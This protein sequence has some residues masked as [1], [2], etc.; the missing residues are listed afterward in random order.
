MPLSDLSRPAAA[1]EQAAEDP[2]DSY[3]RSRLDAH[4]QREREGRRTVPGH[5]VEGAKGVPRGLAGMAG[6]AVQGAGVY[7]Q[8]V[9]D[10]FQQ[11]AGAGP[12]AVDP[13]EENPL[14]RVGT[15]LIEAAREAIPVNPDYEGAMSVQVGEAT[16]SLAGFALPGGVVGGVTRKVAGG[17]ALSKAI[18]AN[19]EASRIARGDRFL[20]ASRGAGAADL[21]YDRYAEGYQ[22]KQRI[23]GAQEKAELAGRVGQFGTAAPMAAGAGIADAYTRAREFAKAN[24]E[25]GLSEEE[26]RA[27]AI[28]A[29]SVSGIVQIATL[30]PLFK[31]IP[32]PAKKRSL[33]Y[34]AKRMAE[35]GVTEWT[36]ENAGQVIQNLAQQTYDKDHSIWEMVPESGEA[37]AYS[38]A[39]LQALVFPF[40]RD[41]PSTRTP[42]RPSSD[43]PAAPPATVPP[44][45]D[46]AA[47]RLEDEPEAEST[48]L[49]AL[50]GRPEEAEDPLDDLRE[51]IEMV[52]ELKTAPVP[53]VPDASA[54]PEVPE[55][56]DAQGGEAAAPSV[57]D[58][59]RGMSDDDIAAMIDEEAGEPEAPT[60]ASPSTV[61]TDGEGQQFATVEVPLA[62]LQL[63]EDVP[64]FKAGADEQG[65][66][67]PLEGKFDRLGASPILVWERAD[68]RKEIVSGRHRVDL[69]TRSGEKTIP[70]QVVREADGFT[71]ADAQIADAELNIRD[72]QGAVSDYVSYFTGTGMDENTANERGLLSRARGRDGF[73]ISNLGSGL[74]I[75][76]HATGQITDAAA[77]AI[78]R[79]A[80]GNDAL[81]SLGLEQLQ[82]GATIEASTSLMDAVAAMRAEQGESAPEAGDMFGFDDSA[83]Q[84][85]KTLAK[86]A[87]AKKREINERL[88]AVRG[89][90]KRPEKAAALGVD[91]K[92][93]EGLRAKIAELE[94]EKQQWDSWPTNPQ[95]RQQLL[96][97]SG[98]EVPQ[99]TAPLTPPAEADKN[100]P[101]PGILSAPAGEVSQPDAAPAPEPVMGLFGE[102]PVAEQALADAE[103][104]KDNQRSP[105]T[106]VAAGQGGDMFSAPQADITDAADDTPAPEPDAEERLPGWDEDVQGY[107]KPNGEPYPSKKAAEAAKKSRGL[108]EEYEVFDYV[109]Q[110]D[111]DG[112][113]TMGWAI[114]PELPG[115]ADQM[116]AP[117]APDGFNA[118]AALDENYE[119]TPVDVSGGAIATPDATIDETIALKDGPFISQ[120]EADARFEAWK[121]EAAR[122]GKEEDHSGEVIISLFDS[123]GNFSQPYRDMG[124][125]TIQIDVN[126]RNKDTADEFYEDDILQSLSPEQVFYDAE[127]AGLKVVGVIAQPP[128]TSFAGAG[129]RWW[130][131]KHDAKGQ[132]GAEWLESRFGAKALRDFENAL[133]YNRWLVAMTELYV[134][135]A[136][137]G[138]DL[139]FHV[140]ENPIGRIERETGLPKPRLR[141]NP[142]NYGETYTKKTSFYGEFNPDLPEANVDPVEGSK[143]Q[144]KL[145][146]S[147]EAGDGARSLT[148]ERVAYAF[149]MA[150]APGANVQLSAAPE[151]GNEQPVSLPDGVELIEHTTRKGKV[152]RGIVR[153]DLDEDGAKAID[154][155]SF[156]KDGGWFIGEQ[157]LDKPGALPT[158]QEA[159]DPVA[160]VESMT[161]AAHARQS[162]VMDRFARDGS[163]QLRHI[164]T[165]RDALLSPNLDDPASPEKVRLTRFDDDGQPLGHTVYENLESGARDVALEN[166]Q[167]IEPEADAEPSDSPIGPEEGLT[168]PE[169]EA[170]ETSESDAEDLD[171]RDVYTHAKKLARSRNLPSWQN[172]GMLDR[173]DQHINPGGPM[174]RPDEKAGAE[175]G[176]EADYDFGVEVAE[177]LLEQAAEELSADVR[178][179]VSARLTRADEESSQNPQETLRDRNREPRDWL[180]PESVKGKQAQKVRKFLKN[181]GEII[182]GIRRQTQVKVSPMKVDEVRLV[183]RRLHDALFEFTRYDLARRDLEGR[184]FETVD[185]AYT[186][187]EQT[188]IKGRVL[189]QVESA[190]KDALP[191]HTVNLYYEGGLLDHISAA[192]YVLV[193]FD[194]EFRQSEP[195]ST[196]GPRGASA[197]MSAMSDADLEALIDDVAAD[198][199]AAETE[200]PVAERAPTVTKSSGA[201]RPRK[202]KAKAETGS[203]RTASEIAES[204]GGNLSSAGGNAV[205]GLTELFGGKGRMNSGLSFDEATYARAKPHFQALLRDV[206]AAGQDLRDFIRLVLD[207]FGTAVKPY[208][209][210]FAQDV[211][212][213]NIDLSA[214]EEGADVQPGTQDAAGDRPEGA[215]ADG[216]GSPPDDAGAGSSGDGAGTADGASDASVPGS[217]E[218]GAGLSGSGTAASGAAAT[219][220]VRGPREG[221]GAPDDAAGSADADGSDPDG[222]R[223]V[224]PDAGGTD[225]ATAAAGDGS[226]LILGDR[227]DIKARV[228][229][230]N[231]GQVDD[232]AKAE[233]RFF[234]GPE[235]KRGLGMLFTNGT[236][237]GKAQPL[238]ARVLTPMGWARMGDLSVGDLVISVDGQPTE[239]TGVFPQGDKPIYRVRFSDG[240]ET[241]CCAEH[242]W[243]TQ[244]LYERRKARANPSWACAQPKVRS[245]EEIMATLDAQHFIPIAA[246]VA[247]STPAPEAIPP[248][249]MGV[250]LG[251]GCFRGGSITFASADPQ[252]AQL[253]AEELDDGYSVHQVVSGDRCPAYR[254]GDDV[255]AAP[256]VPGGFKASRM[257]AALKEWNLW[258]RFA[259]EKH[260]PAAYLTA[261]EEDR[262]ALLQ[263]L[264]D[265]DGWVDKKTRSPYFGTS[266]PALADAVVAL[267]RSLGGIATR[268][269]KRTASGR[270]AHVICV[271]LPAGVAP[272]RLGRK[273]SL[274]QPNS[275]YPPRRKIVAVKPVGTKPAQ[276][277]RVAHAS[278]LYVTDDYV[279]THNTFT[280]LGIIKRFVDMGRSN[281][282]ILVP[283]KRV[284]AQWRGLAAEHFGLEVDALK[285]TKDPG[286]DGRIVVTTYA[287]FADNLRILDRE[288][289][290]IVPDE[291]HNLLQEKSGE[292]NERTT[293]FKDLTWDP[294]IGASPYYAR[295]W[296]EWEPLEKKVRAE[297]EKIEAR[298]LAD[299]PGETRSYTAI[300]ADLKKKRRKLSK[301]AMN[302]ARTPF[303]GQFS[304]IWK[305][306]EQ[307]REDA[308]APPKRPFTTFLSA[309]PFG[310][311]KT[312]DY[313]EGYLFDWGAEPTDGGYN[314][315]SARDRF[316]MRHLG[317]RMR[318]N[319]LTEPDADVDVSLMERQFNEYLIKSGAVSRRMLDADADYSRDFVEHE[320]PVG[321]EI[322]RGFK[323]LQGFGTDGDRLP[324]EQQFPAIASIANDAYD[325][326]YVNA[327]LEGLNTR[328]A[329]RRTRAHM[330]LGRQVVVFHRYKTRQASH[331]FNFESKLWQDAIGRVAAAAGNPDGAYR[332]KAQFAAEVARFKRDHADL[333]NLD[334]SGVEN[335]V[336]AFR[337]EFGDDVGIFNGDT[338]TKRKEALPDEFNDDSISPRVLLVQIQAGKEGISLHD[339]TGKYPRA[340]MSIGL[341]IQATDTIQM[342][343]RIIRL[344]QVSNAVLEY[345]TTGLSIEQWAFANAIARRSSTAEN[346]AMG[347]DA[348]NLLRAFTDGYESRAPMDPS[349]EQGTGAKAKD[350]ER[351]ETDPFDEARSY[352]YSN[353]KATARTKAADGVDYFPTPEPLGL[354]MVEWL[355]LD[356]AE[357]ALE[358]SAGHGAIAR[359]FPESVKSDVVEPSPVLRGRLGMNAPNSSI[360]TGDFEGLAAANKYHGIAMNPPYGTGGKTA[361]EHLEKA[362]KHLY[363]GGRVIAIVPNGPSFWKRYENWM[364]GDDTTKGVKDVHQVARIDLP[365]ITFKRAGTSVRTSILVLD[366]AKKHTPPQQRTDRELRA[367]TIDD[368]FEMLRDMEMPDR[369]APPEPEPAPLPG[370]P[371]ATPSNVSGETQASDKFPALRLLEFEHSRDKVTLYAAKHVSN[372]DRGV[373][374]EM[375]GIARKHGG[376]WSR[377]QSKASGAVPSFVFRTAE[378]RQAFASEISGEAAAPAAPAQ[379]ATPRFR[380]WFGDSVLKNE[381]G[382]PMRLYHQTTKSFARFRPGGEDPTL[383]GPA[384]WLSLSP[385]N[386]PNAHQGDMARRRARWGAPESMS[387]DEF[388]EFEERQRRS[389]AEPIDLEGITPG[390]NIMPVYARLENPARYEKDSRPT[391]TGIVYLTQDDVRS[392]R[393]QGHDG[394]V[395]ILDDGSFGEV[396]VFDP[397]QVKSAIGNTGSFDPS[398][399]Y[400]TMSLPDRAPA[401]GL[402]RDNVLDAINDVVLT[403]T[404][405]PVVEV[406]ESWRDLPAHLR[407]SVE[408]QGAFEVEGVLDDADGRNTVY[409]VAGGLSSPA[410]ARK[411][412]AHEAVGHF[413]ME[414]LLGDSFDR[415]IQ[416]VRHLARADAEVAAVEAGVRRDYSGVNQGDSFERTVAAETIA[417][418]AERRI[419]SPLLTR[420]RAALRRFLRSLGFRMAFS[421]V[422]LDA[423]LVNAAR[424]LH[425]GNR[426]TMSESAA[427]FSLPDRSSQ[428]GEFEA[429]TRVR[430][431]ITRGPIDRAFHYAFDVT[432][433]LDSMGRFK[434]GV[435]LTRAFE[436]GLTE[437]KFDENGSMA[438]ANHYLEKARAGLI[439]RY[440][441]DDEYLQRSKEAETDEARILRALDTLMTEIAHVSAEDA[442]L[443]QGV[444]A[445][446]DLSRDDIMR[447]AAPIR[448]A[449]DELGSEL[450]TLGMISAETYERHLGQYLHRTYQ[451]YEG[452]DGLAGLAHQ[453]RKRHRQKLYGDQLRKRGIS[454]YYSTQRLLK[455][456]APEW[457]GRKLKGAEADKQ[458]KGSKWIIFDRLKP[459]GEGTETAPGIEEGGP[460]QRRIMQR[461]IWPADQDV[462]AR[463][464]AWENRGE[465]E[466]IGTKRGKLELH[467]D[468]TREERVQMG[469]ILDARYNII[470]TYQ[471]LAHD[472]A[473]GRFYRDLA[474]NPDW[475]TDDPPGGDVKEDT[476]GRL[477]RLA[478]LAGIDWVLVPDSKI[479][480]TKQK[481][482]GDLGGRYVRAEIWRDLNE[483]DRMRTPDTWRSILGFWK[484][485]KTIR[486]PVVH[487][488]NVMSNLW[489]M[490]MADMTMRDLA[491]AMSEWRANGEMLEEARLHA[492]FNAGFVQQ[493]LRRNHID[494]LLDELMAEAQS[495]SDDFTGKAKFWWKAADAI[496]SRAKKIDRAAHDAYEFEDNIFRLGLYM[497]LRDQG[498]SAEEASSIVREQFLDYDIRAPWVNAARASVLPFISYT[499]RAV[500]IIAQSIAHRPWKLAKYITLG[501]AAN[502]L[503]YALSPGDEDEERRT[504]RE[505]MQGTTW[506]SI[507]G[508]DI[509]VHR[510]VRMPWRDD[511]DNPVFI[512]V[513]RWVPAGDV[514]DTNQGQIGLPAWLQFGGPL[515]IAFELALNRS[516]F[517]GR[518]IVDRDTDT[519]GEAAGKRLDYLY[520]AWMPSAAF[521]PGSWHYEKLERAL[522][523]ERDLLGRPYDP[524]GATLSGVGIKVQP[525][526]IQLG[527]YYRG[528]EIERKMRDL[529]GQLN[530]LAQDRA[531]NIGNADSWLRTRNTIERK[532]KALQEESARL[533]GREP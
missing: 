273:A 489:L 238:D 486:S 388:L 521:I 37:A 222:G 399:P 321:N 65:V 362:A 10:T 393:D 158:E 470:K 209:M 138:G 159:V 392:L 67:E 434:R 517:T 526:D 205:K 376:Y 120:E 500:P 91:V 282:L 466:V 193:Q 52:E 176:A 11:S 492:A 363:D 401:R 270:D 246:P 245:L 188:F 19:Q 287:N 165:G 136:K 152:K 49:D 113:E 314:S 390:D 13:A 223:G 479:Q 213:G 75:Q 173:L 352:Y 395:E 439:S 164:R 525:H 132:A 168:G 491:R 36:V 472:I 206:E 106:D 514:F 487:T 285:D 348:R 349:S 110:V 311:H 18:Q 497:R 323:L 73:A 405:G 128:C 170:S 304:A 384:I 126:V 510:M 509:G 387:T 101:E 60:G 255:G 354:K 480:G 234:A 421:K 493:E 121:A 51:A 342:E 149:A 122:I 437:A 253:V 458:L 433:S 331:P 494:P 260:V 182:P 80:P 194:R 450:V 529:R 290:L 498:A 291:S 527:Y 365:E 476:P 274:Y 175:K 185:E 24:P 522:A 85:A 74:L 284:A 64:Q 430:K 281:V 40:L 400:I 174:F 353:Q 256:I 436:R 155:Y 104:E 22:A 330:E 239:V 382:T 241:E 72:N 25:F 411:V 191:G 501:Y 96:Q 396:V 70:A 316:F 220:P 7:A 177:Q 171:P 27:L 368:L 196:V 398:S 345:I 457:W 443:L 200:K 446:G 247:S 307:D 8:E 519:T 161:A 111:A 356:A 410:R 203:D 277:I 381:D 187:T 55:V 283:G 225:A 114:G 495:Q 418:L 374:S 183:Y 386:I 81:Q 71:A 302:E 338:P 369:I 250:L 150:N 298:R 34:L 93:P 86:A 63:S 507:P 215:A 249:T 134:S 306:A 38:A 397:E 288:W 524:V 432:G 201:K 483:L 442:K 339:T 62:E 59:I 367:D 53:D 178:K 375:A 420:A 17:R 301:D 123:S 105:G 451:K 355:H 197:D 102:E 360:R 332:I 325:Y 26:S 90:A 484:A 44:A 296:R 315:G 45:A 471:L 233:A 141:L 464:D 378:E 125:R 79:T 153:T 454:E 318:Y 515:Q 124:Y 154:P 130:E 359:W 523:G 426:A 453:W 272:F 341:P 460:K 380:N 244:T 267:A 69:A 370:P 324:D 133:D 505:P 440:G 32:E 461:V 373:F 48:G 190:L 78:A 303:Q 423:M 54:A 449:I 157:H 419:D 21:A 408:A 528:S 412:L 3:L 192:R 87:A 219:E 66:V 477:G 61:L 452:L 441:L 204:L 56:P 417:R 343:G 251:D 334:L 407:D 28:P 403:W 224:S 198:T 422:E 269:K 232:V 89:A 16:G 9:A 236:G 506:A 199:G 512:D 6:A 469:E 76:A 424:S 488:N 416:Q 261:R 186:P 328:E 156:R 180:A 116:T 383:S 262:V 361:M 518:D 68:G 346:L 258:A 211:R 118:I 530:R 240:A 92:D 77:V 235:E 139:A 312:I 108:P 227:A 336:Q 276:C 531:R 357:H 217:G 144:N 481:A 137:Q 520:K 292:W 147:D 322:D 29:G 231:E 221:T 129:A 143:M 163:V 254:I 166:Y 99:P 415:L 42:S 103:R 271:N 58:E 473:Y 445:E 511:N 496:W 43:A 504:M 142:H 179:A 465:W 31:M 406:V 266:S 107:V 226:R 459:I 162:T 351:I 438:W 371:Q 115:A 242:L 189:Y 82:G 337:K 293:K 94:A 308:V 33:A 229:A 533:Q 98:A 218:G 160:L 404:D 478:T 309:S 228:P 425:A 347:N 208:L 23:K 39:L 294:R 237:T 100:P 435:Q 20:D 263:G 350:R 95:L 490:D 148:P 184:L 310:Y 429:Q 15:K 30:G 151:M 265:T 135:R 84:Q 389:G 391:E 167:V 448:E 366:K 12:E 372:V 268:T 409:L 463:F 340:L 326:H 202:K 358:P 295:R 455:D 474:L 444:L 317:Y 248:Y 475:S 503:A 319:K 320:T 394:A 513:F 305:K 462:P 252:V 109:A 2:L 230:L 172:A 280:G 41:A 35:A 532:M 169:S 402:S 210:R 427:S 195:P 364:Y 413:G 212:A 127:Q 117:S 300:H 119:P 278:S 275:K 329:I 207:Q 431:A 335:P 313:A 456:T 468:Y 447:M 428:E 14:Y 216:V 131:S 297:A 1:P 344:G 379:T 414:R 327:L 259:Y 279:V 516:A 57:V 146:S 46:V 140:I 467:R 286:G 88:S 485:N 243:E 83:M 499:Y 333:V 50:Y 377:Y 181:L 97:E 47:E 4:A 482:W 264:L 145:R 5:L 385:E 289:D 508:T 257:K 502:A 214:P 112:N 299:E